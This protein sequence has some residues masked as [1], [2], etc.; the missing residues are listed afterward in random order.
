MLICNGQLDC[1]NGK[2]ESSFICQGIRNARTVKNQKA[3]VG[4]SQKRDL[5]EFECILRINDRSSISIIFMQDLLDLASVVAMRTTVFFLFRMSVT[6]NQ[7]VPMETMKSA[8]VS[9]TILYNSHYC[10]ALFN[11]SP[12]TDSRCPSV[13]PDFPI[14]LPQFFC[15]FVC[16]MLHCTTCPNTSCGSRHVHAEEVRQARCSKNIWRGRGLGG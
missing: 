15:K 16:S 11:V 8:A 1:P 7:T 4:I 9:D 10:F 13:G 6:G 5:Y 2:D 12:N 3:L 14:P